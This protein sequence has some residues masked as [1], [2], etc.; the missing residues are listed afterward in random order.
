L[1]YVLFN[2][3]HGFYVEDSIEEEQ[4]VHARA[5]LWLLF[6]S[7]LDIFSRLSTHVFRS[8]FIYDMP[9]AYCIVLVWLTSTSCQIIWQ[10]TNHIL[11]QLYIKHERQCFIGVPKHR[12]ESWKYMYDVQWSIFDGIRGVWITN[13]TLS[14]VFD[15]SSQ[16]KQ[17]LHVR[18][19][20]RSKFIK[21]YAN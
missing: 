7:L 21:I 15:I 14:R 20:W 19:K 1:F 11:F 13:E 16:S 2:K 8:F 4:L 10:W 6:F 5:V 12:E 18:N 17:K 9:N 3:L